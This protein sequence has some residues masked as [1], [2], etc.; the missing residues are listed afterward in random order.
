MHN[1]NPV[2]F[3]PDCVAG[4]FLLY[5][6]PLPDVLPGWSSCCIRSTGKEILTVLARGEAG[7]SDK[8]QGIPVW[9]LQGDP[10]WKL[11]EYLRHRVLRDR[12]SDTWKALF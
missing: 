6:V 4:S 12:G 2:D 10:Y 8:Y 3:F 7:R 5:P 11:Q 9:I 1:Q